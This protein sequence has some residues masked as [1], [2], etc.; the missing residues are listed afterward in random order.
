MAVAI[1]AQSLPHVRCVVVPTIACAMYL[2]LVGGCSRSRYVA[3]Y[4]ACTTRK[5]PVLPAPETPQ[6]PVRSPPAGTVP[7]PQPDAE[8]R[9]APPRV[10]ITLETPGRI[11]ARWSGRNRDLLVQGDLAGD[12]LERDRTLEVLRSALADLSDDWRDEDGSSRVTVVINGNRE[13]KWNTVQ[14][15][16]EV[17]AHPSVRIF[18]M[19]FA[20]VKSAE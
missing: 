13:A 3:R 6:R 16:M 8:A 20:V 2:L 19:H 4:P 15:L 17:M 18:K 7:A 9:G 1:T 12:A 10:R 5:C 11:A 14:P